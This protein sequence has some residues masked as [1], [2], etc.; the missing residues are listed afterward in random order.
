MEEATRNSILMLART[1]K[2]TSPEQLAAVERAVKGNGPKVTWLNSK[3]ARA[4]LGEADGK[5]IS[6]PYLRKLVTDGLLHP[7]Q[8]SSR[9][10]RYDQ[11]E[12]LALM[13]QA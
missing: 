4:L 2:S 13:Q 12:I 8:L 11:G 3:D 7:K 1:D 9:K 5:P 10:T 6:K